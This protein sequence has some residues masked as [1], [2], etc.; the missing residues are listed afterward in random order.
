MGAHVD[1]LGLSLLRFPPYVPLLLLLLLLLLLPPLPLPLPLP[2]NDCLTD[3]I[4]MAWKNLATPPSS[5]YLD[6]TFSELGTVGDYF[7]PQFTLLPS[8][9]RYL[10]YLVYLLYLISLFLFSS[11]SFSFLRFHSF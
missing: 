3:F 9:R 8:F 5:V 11:F 6:R 10:P 2:L 1:D 7:L 4:A